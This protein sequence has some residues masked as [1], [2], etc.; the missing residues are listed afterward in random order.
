M[1]PVSGQHRR[2]IVDVTQRFALIMSGVGG[3]AIGIRVC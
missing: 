1:I 2:E 3:D